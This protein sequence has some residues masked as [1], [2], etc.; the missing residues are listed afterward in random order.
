MSSGVGI[1]EV[2]AGKYR[3]EA[4]LGEGGMGIVFAAHHLDLGRTVAIKVMRRDLGSDDSLVRRLM[5][6]ARAA[7]RIQSEHVCQVLDVSRLDDGTPFIVMEHLSGRDLGSVLSSDGPLSEHRAVDYVLQACEPIA[8]AHRAG[9]VHRDLKPENL[10]LARRADGSDLI[11]VLDFGI[12]K[13]TAASALQ[14]HTAHTMANSA[15]GS[16][17]YMAPNAQMSARASRSPRD[18]ICSG[19]M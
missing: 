17:Y 7:A 13:A 15:V 14:V 19:A 5:F 16:P 3:V 10:F 9:I 18:A 4:V 8:E 2:L 1:G 12:S 11:K 6:E